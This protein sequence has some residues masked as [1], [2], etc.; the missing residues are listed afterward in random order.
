MKINEPETNQTESRTRI[1][2]DLK[3]ILTADELEQFLRSAEEA[4]A[5]NL[6]EHFLNITLRTKQAA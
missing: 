6:R 2:F 5:P 1:V 3:D 4:H